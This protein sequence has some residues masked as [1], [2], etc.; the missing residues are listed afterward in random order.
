M[1][2]DE[3]Y[4]EKDMVLGISLNQHNTLLA[5]GTMDDVRVLYLNPATHGGNYLRPSFYV[6][7][8]ESEGWLGLV[9]GFFPEV[10]PCEPR[11]TDLVD[12]EQIQEK[13]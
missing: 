13:D 5:G 4:R 3:P 7:P 12:F 9:D 1:S 10:S 6:K 11:D 8:V 2:A